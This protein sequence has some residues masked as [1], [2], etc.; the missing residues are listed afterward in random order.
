[1]TFSRR[2]FIKIMGTSAV[3]CAVGATGYVITRDPEAA[4]KPW[5]QAGSG[6]TDPRLNAVSFAILA[7]NPHNM[8]PWQV[9]LV[10]QDTL[11]LYCDPERLLPHTDPFS[12]QIVIGLGCFLELLRMAALADGYQ[13]NITPFPEGEFAA[14]PDHRPVARVVFSASTRQPDPLF[15]QVLQRRSNKE[16]YA[17]DQPVSDVEL[18]KLTAISLDGAQALTSNDMPL[19]EQLRKL[20]YAAHEIEVMTPRTLQ[21]SIDVM[22]IGKAEIE[23]SPDGIDLG[24]A[25]LETL[26]RL[27]L[28]TREKLAD[29]QAT[30]FAQGLDMY[31]E[32][33]FS[34]MAYVWVITPGNGRFDQLNAGAAWLRINLQATAQ[35]LDIHPISQALQE[36]PEMQTLYEQLP[37]LLKISPPQHLQM[38][39]RLGY[40][41]KNILPAPRWPAETRLLET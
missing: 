10:G 30:A 34:A 15:L 37:R 31:H 20:T 23:A 14:T 4:R 41:P 7:P 22:R 1:M 25:L 21:E 26:N 38:L 19:V 9:K 11:E 40:G 17:L 8:Q 24:G 6:Y 18:N 27:G 3:V 28:L 33:L 12:R 29:P 13:A 32:I 35:K 16:P 39:G 36:Y 5:K 2:R